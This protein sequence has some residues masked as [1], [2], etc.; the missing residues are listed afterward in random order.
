MHLY[1]HIC[2]IIFLYEITD[3]NIFFLNV[4]GCLVVVLS[5][6]IRGLGHLRVWVL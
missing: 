4:F 2:K 5:A 6:L 3:V 1:V